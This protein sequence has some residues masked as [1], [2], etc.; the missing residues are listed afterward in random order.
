MD[1]PEKNCNSQTELTPDPHSPNLTVIMP[2]PNK[3]TA[4]WSTLATV[5]MTVVVSPGLFG[6][7][8][9]QMHEGFIQYWPTLNT[10]IVQYQYITWGWGANASMVDMFHLFSCFF[11]LW[12]LSIILLYYLTNYITIQ[13]NHC[14]ITYKLLSGTWKWMKCI[15]HACIGLS[16]PSNL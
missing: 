10:E 7:E 3:P 15:C 1:P 13:I 2:L 16:P 6:R 11:N 5:E 4:H 12:I 8:P 9:S 14:D